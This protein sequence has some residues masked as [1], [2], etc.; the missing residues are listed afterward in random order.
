MIMPELQY[1]A[2]GEGNT[3]FGFNGQE[4]SD[5]V[6]GKGSLNTALFWEYDTRLGRRWNLDPKQQINIS[7]YST[8][9]GNPIA[10]IDVNGDTKDYYQAEEGGEIVYN[11][12]NESSISVDGVQYKN[13]GSTIEAST[14]DGARIKGDACGNITVSKT[15]Q[16]FEVTSTTSGENWAKESI[17]GYNDGTFFSQG[18]ESID[19]G[20]LC[21]RPPDAAGITFTATFIPWMGASESISF[22][23]MRGN[24]FFATHTT[25]GGAG[26]DV[27]G[28]V[29][30][31]GAYYDG[32]KA[33][34]DYGSFLG[35]S[36]ANN[37]GF[38]ILSLGQSADISE[39]NG[40]IQCG[41]NW[42][43]VSIGGALG[44]DDFS[45]IISANSQIQ[46]STSLINPR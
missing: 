29:S 25:G 10:L 27:S 21:I 33:A 44:A 1:N 46:W 23:Y 37:V 17:S 32:P 34:P 40:Q 15:L 39:Q 6:Y 12:G 36:N 22:G 24:G 35:M 8:F 28:G 13:I 18:D 30:L 9:G 16:E 42:N 5:E 7:D 41:E 45:T 38:S 11:E 31:F 2:P 19:Y 43:S 14:N 26:W 4:R 3:R 20:P